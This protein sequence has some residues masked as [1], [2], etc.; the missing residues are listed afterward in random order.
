MLKSSEFPNLRCSVLLLSTPFC[1]LSIDTATAS[2]GT[3]ATEPRPL[4]PD[5]LVD[6]MG[7]YAGKLQKRSRGRGTWK[8]VFALV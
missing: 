2:G 6:L 8:D 1:G 4:T 5:A 7:P 3:Q